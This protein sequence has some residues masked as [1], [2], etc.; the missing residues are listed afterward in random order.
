MISDFRGAY[1]FLSNFYLA[2]TPIDGEVY[3]T[4]EHA[5]QAMKSAD[6]AYRV[7]V[8]RAPT[9]GQ[10]KRLG[11]AVALRADWEAVKIDVMRDVVRAKFRHNPDLAAQLLATGDQELVEGNAWG[12][13]FW[14]VCAGR[15][16]NWLG[17]I[18]MEVRAELRGR[19]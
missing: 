2:P 14:G 16:R 4:S 18:L 11:R 19:T 12:D 8:L 15:G 6:P 3:L 17:K 1:A 7:S 5:F 13:K 10:A 9:P